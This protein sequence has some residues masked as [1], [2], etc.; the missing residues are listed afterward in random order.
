MKTYKDLYSQV[1]SFE[2]LYL[3]YLKARTEHSVLH[4]PFPIPYFLL[5]IIHDPFPNYHS[6]LTIIHDHDP[7]PNYQLPITIPHPLSPI[8]LKIL[9]RRLSCLVDP[10]TMDHLPKCHEQD[11]DIQPE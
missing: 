2:N 4:L 7:F 3:A 10:L 8:P 1:V 11:L 6:P 9:H 5:A